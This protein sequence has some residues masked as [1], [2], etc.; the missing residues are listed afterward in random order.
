[1]LAIKI[2]QMPTVRRQR[3]NEPQRLR[4]V[5]ESALCGKSGPPGRSLA[6]HKRAMSVAASAAMRLDKRFN[7]ARVQH[8]MRQLQT[9]AWSVS[10]D[11]LKII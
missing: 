4:V 6:R 3:V 2:K 9:S 1:M 7:G 10:A 5:N 8:V 11:R